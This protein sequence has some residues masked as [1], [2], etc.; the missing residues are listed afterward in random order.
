MSTINLH[1]PIK[2]REL[3]AS[4]T[5]EPM[6]DVE[7]DYSDSMVEEIATQLACER[8]AEYE[9]YIKERIK[10]SKPLEP[11]SEWKE[12]IKSLRKEIPDSAWTIQIEDPTFIEAGTNIGIALEIRYSSIF[13]TPRKAYERAMEMFK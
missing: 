4:W 7:F 13:D 8:T 1:Q 2:T 12:V 3:T 10:N 9:E 5:I 11:Q 6:Q